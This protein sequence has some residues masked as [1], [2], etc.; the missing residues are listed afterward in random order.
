VEFTATVSAQ[1]ELRTVVVKLCSVFGPYNRY[2]SY[3]AVTAMLASG[4][5]KRVVQYVNKQYKQG[6]A[7]P[8]QAWT[9]G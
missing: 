7:I 6:E 3:Q 1:R 2:I 9:G 4:L 5:P 8:L